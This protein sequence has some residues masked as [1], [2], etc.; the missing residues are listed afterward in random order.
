MQLVKKG[1]NLFILGKPGAGKTTFL[2]YLT[3]QAAQYK[4]NQLPIFIS[5]NEWANNR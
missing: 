2:K 4:L 1:K 5:L 3:V